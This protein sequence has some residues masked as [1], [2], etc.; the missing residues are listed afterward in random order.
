MI[1]HFPILAAALCLGVFFFAPVPARADGWTP[2]E[3]AKRLQAAYD[4]TNTLQADFIQDTYSRV[5]RRKKSGAGSVILKKPGLMRWDYKRPDI[6]VMVCDGKTISMYFAREKQ[7]VVTAAEEYLK[8]D[9]MYSFFAGNGNIVNDFEVLAPE[10]DELS[11]VPGTVQIKLV[12]KDSHAQVDFIDVWVDIAN[13]LL[14]R[15]AVT[16]TF[17]SVTDIRFAN[18]RVNE[19]VKDRVFTFTPPPDTEIVKQ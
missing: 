13:E 12:P 14:A 6:Q 7:M 17:G 19:E 8:S 15:I 3:A 10:K 4:R 11:P 1:R 5:S 9:V 2:A 16:D 18:I